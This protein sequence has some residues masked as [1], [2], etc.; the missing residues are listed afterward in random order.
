MVDF[1]K[2]KRELGGLKGKI[3]KFEKVLEASSE[4]DKNLMKEMYQVHSPTQS[5]LVKIF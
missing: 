2:F 4:I 5:M 3:E 1:V